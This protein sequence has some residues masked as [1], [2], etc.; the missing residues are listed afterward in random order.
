MP[1]LLRHSWQSWKATKGLAL[2]GVLALSVGIA[3]TT[4]IFSVVHA[5]LLK[6]L[7][8]SEGNRW[9]ALFGGN[10]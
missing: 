9:V 10:R 3:S 7:P 4:A 1:P 6:P 2:L 5:V 8:Y